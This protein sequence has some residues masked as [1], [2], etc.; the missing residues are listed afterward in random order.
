MWTHRTLTMHHIQHILVVSLSVIW[1]F[2]ISIFWHPNRGQ[3]SPF[4]GLFDIECLREWSSLLPS[5][6]LWLTLTIQLSCKIYM[7]ILHPPTCLSNFN[8]NDLSE[9]F[10]AFAKPGGLLWE[11]AL[12]ELVA[13]LAG[14]GDSFY[15]VIAWIFMEVVFSSLR[16]EV[17]TLWYLCLDGLVVSGTHLC[18]VRDVDMKR[19]FAFVVSTA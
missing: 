6:F 7:K 17:S 5:H 3:W 1:G 13:N 2:E 16:G 15:N 12:P 4:L 10:W 11:V 18:R 19:D 14:P 8:L 9:G